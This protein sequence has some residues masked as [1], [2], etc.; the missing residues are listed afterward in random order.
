[1]Y[2][3]CPVAISKNN[4]CKVAIAVADFNLKRRQL[5]MCCTDIA[6]INKPWCKYS[7]VMFH[8][9]LFCPSDNVWCSRRRAD[10]PR[11]THFS[12]VITPSWI[13]QQISV[14]NCTNRG[15]S[16]CR[17]C[18]AMFKIVTWTKQTWTKH[19]WTKHHSKYCNGPGFESW[20]LPA[21]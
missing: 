21:S 1:M 12:T 7:V 2:R 13:T 3:L 4:L 10:V 19:T 9:C 6:L 8:P 14:E 18:Q 15:A 17:E 20:Q 5:P 11:C 16:A